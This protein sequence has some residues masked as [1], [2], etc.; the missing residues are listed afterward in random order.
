VSVEESWSCL[1]CFLMGH[2]HWEI[3][4]HNSSNCL[5]RYW[6]ICNCRNWSFYDTCHCT[7]F[8][9]AT[10]F[11]TIYRETE[12]LNRQNFCFLLENTIQCKWLHSASKRYTR[13]TTFLQLFHCVFHGGILSDCLTHLMLSAFSRLNN[14][15]S[16]LTVIL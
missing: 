15:F 2:L 11:A 10:S 14:S 5:P 3:Y 6:R 7:I 13:R 4:L 8:F 1:H 12:I 9:S 16:S